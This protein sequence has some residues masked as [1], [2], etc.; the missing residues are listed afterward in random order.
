MSRTL[1]FAALAAIAFAAAAAENPDVARLSQRLAALRADPQ[2][3]GLAPYERIQA[4]QAVDAFARAKRKQREEFLYLA[5]KRVEI[6]ETAARTAEA[7]R[8]LDELDDVRR[9]LMVE[10]SRQEAARVRAENERLRIQA[11]IQAE[12]AERLRLAA[13]AEAQARL[14]AEDTLTAV[15]GQQAARLSAAQRKEAQLAREE[16]ELVSGAK[17]PSSKF[18]QRGEVFTLAGSVFESGSASLSASGKDTAGAIAAY[19]AARPKTRARID[20]YGDGGLGQ[21]RADALRDALVAAGVGRS[22][23]QA[24]GKGKATQARA[25]EVVVSP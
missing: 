8:E 1:V 24:G 18:E 17:L 10:A 21:R 4:Q 23:L 2:L 5:E 20:G 22:R 13:E 7:K 25:A 6:A 3:G 14:E 15:A 16:A 9:D 12:E 11:Q 19:L